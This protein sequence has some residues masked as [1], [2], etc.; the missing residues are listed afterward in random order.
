MLAAM[1]CTAIVGDDAPRRAAVLV[2]GAR[3]GVM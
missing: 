2:R 1:Y 3:V